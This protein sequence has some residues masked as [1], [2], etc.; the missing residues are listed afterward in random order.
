MRKLKTNEKFLISFILVLLLAIAFTW[1]NFS[2]RVKKAMDQQS[3]DQV[4][5]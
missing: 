5:E 1:E 2:K 3:T 4:Q